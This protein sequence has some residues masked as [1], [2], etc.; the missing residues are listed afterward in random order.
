[1]K[2]AP[3][4]SP[5]TWKR[6]DE[7]RLR[8]TEV[9]TQ[10]WSGM[11]QAVLSV[12]TVAAVFVA[13]WVALQGQQS[14]KSATQNN[15][16]QAQDNQFSTALTSL[17]SEDVTERIAGLALLELNAADRLTSTSIAAF[18]KPSAYNYYT[19]TL[20]IFS[21]FLH[22]H[23]VGGMTTAGTAVAQPFGV[24]Y[25]APPPGA[26]SI[27]IQYAADEIAKMLGLKNQVRAVS[28]VAPAF[29]LDG[30]ELYEVNLEGMNLSWV[31]AYM[32][33]I[34][35]RGAVLEK[36]H[37]SSLDDVENSHL[38]CAD[39]KYAD[40][41]GADLKDANLSGADL[42]HADL[43][44]ANLTGADLQGAYVRGANFSRA[45]DS[46]ATLTSMY[47]TA[48]G[49]PLGVVTTP[50]QPRIQTPCLA[51]PSYGDPPMPNPAPV[52][53]PSA[54]SSSSVIGRKE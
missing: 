40:L 1:M 7:L 14:L 26:F 32:F 53:S 46:Q 50:G 38:Q 45:Q 5:D 11:A 28:P 4:P 36:L 35:L 30:D 15:L 48:V 39:L 9:R 2:S 49:L 24:G 27:D 31:N 23:G 47:G 6:P 8:K 12:A 52:S 42:Y 51:N 13:L 16:Q 33:G 21:G 29:D 41:Q 54:T 34:D 18:G 43:Q 3:T 17:G 37:L 25:G 44:G 10:I 19:T 22:S 20:E